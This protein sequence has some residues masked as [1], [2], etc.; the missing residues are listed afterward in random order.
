MKHTIYVASSW[1][2]QVQPEVVTALREYGHEVYDFRHPEPM[3][4]GFAWSEIDENWLGWTPDEFTDALEHPVAL[5]GYSLDYAAMNRSDMG[6][7]VLPS[8]RSAHIE[9]G[10]LIGQ[11]KKVIILLSPLDFE[12]EL[13]YLLADHIVTSIGE[14]I[15]VVGPATPTPEGAEK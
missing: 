12:P 10:W 15:R 14:L 7:L 4:D 1:R 8:G 11:G 3:N 13:M 5:E 2:N 9:A 6:V